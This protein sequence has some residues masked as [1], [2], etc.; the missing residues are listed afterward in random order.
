MMQ[1]EAISD[2]IISWDVRS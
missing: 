1:S 2:V